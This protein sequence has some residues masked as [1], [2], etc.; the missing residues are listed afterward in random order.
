MP[1]IYDNRY[2]LERRFCSQIIRNTRELR[3]TELWFGLTSFGWLQSRSEW[4]DSRQRVQIDIC[5]T[6]R[7]SSRNLTAMHSSTINAA[8]AC[9]DSSLRSM[10]LPLKVWRYE[11]LL[12]QA[13]RGS[14]E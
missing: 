11:K 1:A 8:L 14:T 10:D 2:C 7:V 13:P 9:K 4:R 6:A 5:R 3:L 12:R